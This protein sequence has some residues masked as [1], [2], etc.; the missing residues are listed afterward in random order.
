MMKK[1]NKLL[2]FLGMFIAAG[3]VFCCCCEK[4]M[5]C[6]KCCSGSSDDTDTE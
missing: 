1:G 5:S 3:L 2:V 6:C 4:L